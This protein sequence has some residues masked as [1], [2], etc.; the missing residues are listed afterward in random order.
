MYIRKDIEHLTVDPLLVTM[1][2]QRMHMKRLNKAIHKQEFF[3]AKQIMDKKPST[4]LGNI[5]RQRYPT[6]TEA[7]RDLDDA[8]ST[9]A[10]ISSLPSLDEGNINQELVQ[11]CTKINLE[12]QHYV[13]HTK[14][15]KKVFLSAK[16][17]YYQAEIM[18]I[19]ITWSSPY[20]F[21][22]VVPDDVDLEVMGTFLEFYTKFIQF[23]MFR[24]YSDAGLVYPP[25]WDQNLDEEGNAGL[26]AITLQRKDAEGTNLPEAKKGDSS[27][28]SKA[29][30]ELLMKSMDKI[31]EADRKAEKEEEKEGKGTAEQT[32]VYNEPNGITPSEEPGSSSSALLFN[33]LHFYLSREVP[34]QS[35][36]FVL[37][38]NSASTVSYPRTVASM[39]PFE[40]SDTRIT[41]EIVD[42]PHLATRYANRIYVQ[43]QWVYDCV[44]QGKLL[45]IRDYGVGATLPPHLSPF[46]ET[47]D[48]DPTAPM[49]ES[50]DDVAEGGDEFIGFD[51]EEGQD[52]EEE[53]TRNNQELEAELAGK[54]VAP[55]LSRQAELK[56][57]RERNTMK[58]RTEENN[59]KKLALGML[60]KSKAKKYSSIKSAEDK[61]TNRTERLKNRKKALQKTNA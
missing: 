11:E 58:Q 59:Q 4:P 35:L 9:I 42:R 48:Y 52:M 40:Q 54:P 25:K 28:K 55:P 16:G 7:L 12:F 37:N 2:E 18:G 56:R 38:S 30:V 17:I 13:M 36:L 44:N 14:S 20:G 10:L 27:K 47:D 51:D 5:I 15:L 31:I 1:R 22:Q 23:V 33:G 21:A 32:I 6:F 43:P 3:D 19:P 8:L 29:K 26:A 53:N 46:G 39:S 49:S 45:D 34:V 41:H 57:K 61:K 24:L 60:S 50:D